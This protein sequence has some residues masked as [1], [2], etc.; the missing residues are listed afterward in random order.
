MRRDDLSL[1]ELPSGDR[2]GDRWM[3]GRGHDPCSQGPSC[4]GKCPLAEACRPRRTWT[5]LSRQIVWT[6]LAF[7]ALGLFVATRSS[8]SSA[9]F[10][11]G[12]LSRPHA[13]ILAGTMTSQRCSACHSQASTS[14]VSWFTSGAKGHRDVGQTDR[15]VDCHHA[16][17][18]RQ[19]AKSA[20]NLPL[21]VRQKIR[22]SSTLASASSRSWHDALPGPAVAQDDLEC[23]VCHRE[24]RGSD[25][26]LLDLSDTQCQTC[27]SDR[28]GSFADSHPD[29][30]Q[31]PYGRGG[32]I[33]FD[34]R[35]HMKKHF[36]FY[37]LLQPFFLSLS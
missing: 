10:K 20:H 2:P 27:H 16:T 24:H 32:A 12:A 36:Q 6:V 17:I 18:D 23:S 29:W 11:P 3:C 13:Q 19:V 33:A 4:D 15:C 26:S 31:W 34:H 37:H 25:A 21:H 35:T 7:V 9:V 22:A 30:M 14:P 28:F 8:I 5:G 1:A